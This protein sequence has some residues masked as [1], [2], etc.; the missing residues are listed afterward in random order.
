LELNLSKGESAI[1]KSMSDIINEEIVQPI[2]KFNRNLDVHQVLHY[3]EQLSQETTNRSLGSQLLQLTTKAI[4]VL[5]GLKAE[6][7]SRQAKANLALSYIMLLDNFLEAADCP[8][9]NAAISTINNRNISELLRD[10]G[11]KEREKFIIASKNGPIIKENFPYIDYLTAAF[12]DSVN[13]IFEDDASDADLETVFN[14]SRINNGILQKLLAFSDEALQ[15]L[16]SFENKDITKEGYYLYFAK[17]L[18]CHK[19]IKLGFPINSVSSVIN[20]MYK[21]YVI[22]QSFNFD[23][24]YGER[25]QKRSKIVLKAVNDF[26]LTYKDLFMIM[27]NF[28]RL[29]NDV[30]RTSGYATGISSAEYNR[31]VK[32]NARLVA[33]EPDLGK[34]GEIM[35]ITANHNC[36]F[37]EDGY[38]MRY[39]D[40]VKLGEQYYIHKQ[41]YKVDTGLRAN[42]DLEYKP[43]FKAL[44]DTDLYNLEIRVMMF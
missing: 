24:S 12:N 11:V 29:T 6:N 23:L 16:K 31:L 35:R 25:Q 39:N 20:F 40:Y 21:S 33:N 7:L 38:L 34:V 42:T 30:L 17:L 26:L 14:V 43:A 41:G 36:Y 22:Q 1:K 15:L 18:S 28:N 8:I 10:A 37:G 9:D 44:T 27:K 4:R 5:N 32:M 2:Y 13:I 3:K 19:I